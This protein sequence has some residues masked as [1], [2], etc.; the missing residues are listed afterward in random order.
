MANSLLGWLWAPG[1]PEASVSPLVGRAGSRIVLGL[2]R[3]CWRADSGPGT[4]LGQS[5]VR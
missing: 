3:A 1:G 2:M 5:W 4:S